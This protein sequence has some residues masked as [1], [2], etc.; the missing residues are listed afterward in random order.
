MFLSEEGSPGVHEYSLA[1]GLKLQSLSVPDL[2][3]NIVTNRSF[4]SLSRLAD[5]GQLIA[6]NEAALTVDGL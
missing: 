4:E 2:F 5:G 1:E 6:A 3:T